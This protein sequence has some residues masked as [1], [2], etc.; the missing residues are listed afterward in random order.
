MERKRWRQRKRR[1]L[2][3]LAALE[4]WE[5]CTLS[6]LLNHNWFVSSTRTT[7]SHVPVLFCFLLYTLS[8]KHCIYCRTGWGKNNNTPKIKNSVISYWHVKPNFSTVARGA[9]AGSGNNYTPWQWS[10]RCV[11]GELIIELS[12]KQKRSRTRPVKFVPGFI[13]GY[14][15]PKESQIIEKF[16]TCAQKAHTLYLEK[17]EKD[18]SLPLLVYE[19][20]P[21]SIVLAGLELCRPGWLNSLGDPLASAS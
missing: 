16:M 19:T 9:Q 15:T 3:A 17:W 20:L 5:T 4:E 21:H 13:S 12:L 11:N 18:R 7:V 14:L 2:A 8:I 6:L 1:V 10:R